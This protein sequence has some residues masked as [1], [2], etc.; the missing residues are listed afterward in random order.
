M[1]PVNNRITAT[2]NIDNFYPLFDWLRIT[3]AIVVALGHDKVIYWTHVGNLS[4]QVFFWLIGWLI[5]GILL[6]TPKKDLTRFF[7]NRVTRIW[8]PS[9]VGYYASCCSQPAS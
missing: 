7:F 3:L 4:V 1:K 5:G 6:K 8:M 9:Y 2:G